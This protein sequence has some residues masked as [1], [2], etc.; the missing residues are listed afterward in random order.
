MLIFAVDD[1]QPSLRLLHRA[2]EEAAPGAEIM[3]FCLGAEAVRAIGEWGLRPD[4]VFS[5]VRMPG[6]DG[7]AL[8]KRLDQLA[9][10]TK[11]VFV[12]GHP[13]YAVEAMRLHA[14]GYILKPVTAERVREELLY[15]LPGLMSPQDSLRVQCFGRF[16]VFWQDRPLLFGR[17]QTKELL[18]YLIDQEGAV[19][20]AEEIAAALWE[21]ESDMG[22]MKTRIRQLVSDLKHTLAAIGLED[23]LIRRRGQLALRSE[24]VDCDYYR[25]LRGDMDAMNAFRGEYMS[26]YSWASISEG[27]LYFRE[28]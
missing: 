6:L 28:K 1:E 26:Q 2:I 9:P 18:A 22:A 8:A 14:D 17:R 10:A 12:T 25:M 24:C 15:N 23:A 4:I 3:D 16:E 11:L 19:C 13:E 21:N 27:K 5:D 20:T 7:L